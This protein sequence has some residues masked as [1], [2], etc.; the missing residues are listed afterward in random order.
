MHNTI[1]AIY[2][3][4]SKEDEIPDESNSIVNQRLLIRAYINQHFGNLDHQIVEYIDDGYSGKNFQRPAFQKLVQD[5]REGK[6]GLILVKDLSRLGRDY[7]EVGNYVESV[8]PFMGIRFISVNNGFDSNELQYGGVEISTAFQNILNDLYSEEISVKVK[9]S[10]RTLQHQ[11]AFLAS[12]APYGYKKDTKDK[13]R[14][15]IDMEASQ[16]VKYIFKT[17]LECQNKAEVARRLSAK[18]VLTPQQ[19]KENKGSNFKTRYNKTTK[20][21]TSAQVG[22]IIRNK[23]YLGTVISHTRELMGT[24]SM[25]ARRV[26]KDEWVV[27]ENRH[28]AI[29][30]QEE[31]VEAQ[32]LSIKPPSKKEKRRMGAKDSPIKGLVKCGGCKH[33]LNRRSRFH[34]TY[35]C[36]HYYAH[37][38]ETCLSEQIKEEELLHIIEKAIKQQAHVIMNI[39]YLITEKQTVQKK[40]QTLVRQ[41]ET[42]LVKK[43]DEIKVKNMGMYES[44][45]AGDLDREEFLLYKEKTERRKREVSAEL[46]KVRREEEIQ[47]ESDLRIIKFFEGKTHITELTKEVVGLLI[48]EIYIY[49]KK[50]IEIR[51]NFA[52]EI[53]ELYNIAKKDLKI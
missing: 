46:E 28:E 3:R 47:F 26:P 33:V 20:F 44:Y 39:S 37:H 7:I 19:Y 27:N 25:L 29:I 34:A 42:K 53:M 32:L 10:L 51:F 2:L 9:T 30:S 23:V 43:L 13:H 14:L 16:I 8:F 41:K 49:S 6:I 35:E 52:D 38:N 24:G 12:F 36:R 50:R 15:V 45:K 40:S 17:F 21:W 48:S 11:G 5:M 22:K 18:G 31:F 1:V 4:L